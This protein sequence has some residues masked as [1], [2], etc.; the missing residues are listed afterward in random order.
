MNGA[1]Y[2]VY[3]D[4]RQMTKNNTILI[5]LK[6]GEKKQKFSKQLEKFLD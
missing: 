2:E 3:E 5:F 4:L 6:F 1:K